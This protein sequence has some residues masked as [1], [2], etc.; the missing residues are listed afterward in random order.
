MEAIATHLGCDLR[1]EPRFAGRVAKAQV[2]GRDLWL[3]E[4]M[5]F[6]NLSGD[7][8]GKLARYYKIAPEAVLVAHDELDLPPGIVRLKQGG[9]AGG[10]NGLSDIIEKLGT[11][12]FMRLR[13]GIGRPSGNGTQVVSYVLGRAPAAEQQLIDAAID[14]A[15]DHLPDLVEGRFQQ[16]M[17]KLHAAAG[18][19]A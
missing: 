10:H 1:N 8:V 17:N 16:V 3:L 7:S 19:A 5:T 4:P 11:Q 2:G 15:R 14:R 13:L 12:S 18:G 6:M 9:G